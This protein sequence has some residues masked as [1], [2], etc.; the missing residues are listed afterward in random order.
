MGKIKKKENKYSLHHCYSAAASGVPVNGQPAKVSLKT[1]Y[2]SR[3]FEQHGKCQDFLSNKMAHAEACVGGMLRL[4]SILV[5]H[6]LPLVAGFPFK[7][8]PA[9]PNRV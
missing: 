7:V 6:C 2:S 9:T 5:Q 1:F 8:S 3:F 4:R